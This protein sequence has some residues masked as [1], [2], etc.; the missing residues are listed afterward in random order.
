MPLQGALSLAHSMKILS[1]ACHMFAPMA[2]PSLA[3]GEPSYRTLNSKPSL[4]AGSC[5]PPFFADVA[6]MSHGLV[7]LVFKPPSL[8]SL[9]FVSPF[10][11]SILLSTAFGSEWLEGKKRCLLWWACPSRRLGSI[12]RPWLW[13]AGCI[14]FKLPAQSALSETVSHLL[15]SCKVYESRNIVSV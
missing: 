10:P 9:P 8:H 4:A 7:F 6:F 13:H 12:A 3:V 11:L 15:K 5:V 14:L 1:H 2:S